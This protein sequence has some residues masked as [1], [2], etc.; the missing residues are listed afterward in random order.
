M[1]GKNYATTHIIILITTVYFF[2]SPGGEKNGNIKTRKNENDVW[3]E[4]F[5]YADVKMQKQ[6]RNILN[7]A[8]CKSGFRKKKKETRPTATSNRHIC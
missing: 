1:P 4:E 6:Q 8:I 2:H 7:T 3:P 5:V